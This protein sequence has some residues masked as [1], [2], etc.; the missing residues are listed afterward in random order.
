MFKYI[1][2]GAMLLHDIVICWCKMDWRSKYGIHMTESWSNLRSSQTFGNFG[3]QWNDMRRT[4][5]ATYCNLRNRCFMFSK[6]WEIPTF[7]VAETKPSQGV[8]RTT[9]TSRLKIG[10]RWKSIANH[11]AFTQQL[12]TIQYR[13]GMIW[14]PKKMKPLRKQMISQKGPASGPDFSY[15]RG[16]GE[17]S[18]KS[19]ALREADIIGGPA[20][21][22]WKKWPSWDPMDFFWWTAA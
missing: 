21:W 11:A 12:Q 13:H 17:S 7:P 22:R 16:A 6:L 9:K 19:S 5:I 1:F 15:P 14:T 2:F 4:C 3:R 8:Q 18:P 20:R 10:L